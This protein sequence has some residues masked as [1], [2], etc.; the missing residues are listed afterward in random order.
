MRTIGTKALG[1]RAPIIKPGDDLKEI[2]VQSVL[3]ARDAGELEVKDKDILAITESILARDENNYCTIEEVK[4]DLQS[5]FSSDTIGI[6]FPITSRNRFAIILRAIAL[7]FKKV[8]IQFS[9]PGDEVGNSLLDPELVEDKIDNP[10]ER[11]LTKAQFEEIFGNANHP[12]TG[13]DYLSYYQQLV[14][15]SNAQC[16]IIL[17]NNPLELLKH[18]KQIIVG[19]THSRFTLKK[20]L[21]KNGAEKVL[22]LDEIMNSPIHNSGYNGKYGLLGSNKASED[23]LKLFPVS[24]DKFVREVQEELLNKTGKKVEVMIYGDGAF[25]DPVGKIWEL[26][27]PVVSPG[28]TDGLEGTPNELKLKYLADNEF[29]GLKGEELKTAIEKKIQT[30]ETTLKG[31]METEGTTPRRITDL[32]GSLCDLVSGS[33]DKGT[34]FVYIQGYF[35]NY[36]SK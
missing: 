33:G 24:C 25:K 32:V 19:T 23:T 22:G 15:E 30:K 1:L 12:F 10:Y 27:D 8:V 36:G 20:R 2:V 29:K 26:A 7:A 35:D 13:V 9:Y 21:L 17:A 16:E 14:E 3:D 18:T 34:P 4:E 6:L 11:V 31:K 28:Y 5:K